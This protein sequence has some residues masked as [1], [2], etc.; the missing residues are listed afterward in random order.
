V[1]VF[2]G[3]YSEYILSDRR[4]RLLVQAGI[5]QA[6]FTEDSLWADTWARFPVHAGLPGS[7]FSI[8]VAEGGIEAFSVPYHGC[9]VSP[10]EF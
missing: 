8:L 9:L 2:I 3:E 7:S 5:D 4:S 6:H 1:P 10:R